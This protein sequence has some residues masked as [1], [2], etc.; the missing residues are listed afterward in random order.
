MHDRHLQPLGG[1]RG[2]SQ[3]HRRMPHDHAT[4]GVIVRIA[5]REILQHPYQRERQERQV[6]EGRGPAGGLAV[7]VAPQ[8]VELGDVELLDVGKVRNVALGLAHALRDHAAQSDDLDLL[9]GRGRRAVARHR[10]GCCTQ[11]RGCGAAARDERLEVLGHDTA[12]GA[13]AGYLL[14]VDPGLVRAPPDGGRR[15]DACAAHGEFHRG[16]GAIAP[17][18]AEDRCGG[19]G[20]RCGGRLGRRGARAGFDYDEFRAHRHHVTGSTGG[21]DHPA[22]NGSRNLHRSLL[23]HDLDEHVVL[24]HAVAGLDAPVDDLGLDRTFA[25][26]GKLEH[27]VAHVDSITSFRAAAMRAG[28][29]KYSHSNACG[30]GVSQPATRWIG[31]SRFQ[32]HCSCT[33]ATSS[34]P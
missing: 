29:G 34:A 6:G 19:N 25:E 23:R 7:E 33:V 12:V 27:V 26:V 14:Q 22:A 3:V 18:V 32:K 11:R 9:G 24:G 16:G 30:Y 21:G 4:L 2:H 13:R 1:L 31:A 8:R 5:L 15:C 20:W 10:L 28:P 17:A